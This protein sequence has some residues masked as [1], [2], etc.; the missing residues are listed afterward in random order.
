MYYFGYGA[1]TNLEH[2]AIRCPSAVWA[3]TAVLPR[4]ALRFRIHADIEPDD[5]KSVL[6]VLWVI[7]EETL[8]SLDQYEG[9]PDYY[10]RIVT[11]VWQDG[12]PI[13]AT[14]YMMTNQSF[15]DLPDQRYFAVCRDG[16]DGCNV[17]TA[18]LYEAI[19]HIKQSP[20]WDPVFNRIKETDAR[21][22]T[23]AVDKDEYYDIDG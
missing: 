13:K 20:Q 9:Y 7:D 19:E 11:E 16:Y 22:F 5:S 3:G 21:A 15:E 1:N 6:G 2:M 4:H 23:R 12:E 10:T 18:Q 17:P 14:V 8:D